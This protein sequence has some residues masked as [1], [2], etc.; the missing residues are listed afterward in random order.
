MSSI[1]VEE[2]HINIGFKNY[3]YGAMNKDMDDGLIFEKCRLIL[4][5]SESY[6]YRIDGLILMPIYTKVKG[7]K[8]GK[9]VVNIGGTWEY[10]FKW[11]P[12]EEN[13]IDFKLSFEKDPKINKDKIYPILKDVDGEQ[14]LH[15]YKKANLIVGYDQRQDDTLDYCMMLLLNERKKLSKEIRFDPPNTN[16]MIN[17]TNLLLHNGKVVCED[18]SEIRDGDIVEM[19]FNPNGENDMIWEPLRVRYDKSVPQFFTIANNVWETI[20]NPVSENVIKGLEPHIYDKKEA[21]LDDLYYVGD[22]ESESVHFVNII[23][24]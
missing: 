21:V 9:D 15:R 16:I 20:S 7:D 3:E 11:K 1:V 14:I 24:S 12:P 18:D 23:I 5:S 17:S 2:E 6:E 4:E 13:T 10:N 19:R 22:V 8:S